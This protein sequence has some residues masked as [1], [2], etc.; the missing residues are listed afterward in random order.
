MVTLH[1]LQILL[2]N[3]IIII[4]IINVITLPLP[5]LLL[6]T[7]SFDTYVCLVTLRSPSHPPRMKVGQKACFLY[8]C[9]TRWWRM[10]P[11]VCWNTCWD[12][13]EWKRMVLL[14]MFCLFIVCWHSSACMASEE[15]KSDIMKWFPVILNTVQYICS[16]FVSWT[17]LYF[18]EYNVHAG[19]KM[20]NTS[21]IGL[22]EKRLVHCQWVLS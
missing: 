10:C 4:I 2:T 5:T 21:F 1:T 6:P 13:R 15:I 14:M 19:K 17:Q 3:I 7:S 16:F 20:C 11:R 22:R 12:W 8:L 18:A 9:C